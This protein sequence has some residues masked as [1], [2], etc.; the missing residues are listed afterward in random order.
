MSLTSAKA[1]ANTPAFLF[2]AGH[3]GDGLAE[4]GGGAA[5]KA[6]VLVLVLATQT[7]EHEDEDEDKPESPGDPAFPPGDRDVSILSAWRMGAVALLSCIATTQT[8]E[9]LP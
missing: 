3:A 4:P 9:P 5:T 7:A 6:F 8:K 2:S 1:G